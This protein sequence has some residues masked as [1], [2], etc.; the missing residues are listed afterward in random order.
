[1]KGGVWVEAPA[2]PGGRRL[3]RPPGGPWDPSILDR[4]PQGAW[5][6][7]TTRFGGD[8]LPLDVPEEPCSL[9][10]LGMPGVVKVGSRER[11]AP[12]VVEK[13]RGEAVAFF[14]GEWGLRFWVGI[15][16]LGSAPGQFLP[17]AS[18]AELRYIPLEEP[19]EGELIAGLDSSRVGMRLQGFDGRLH[20]QARS[21]PSVFGAIQ[22]APGGELLVHGP[23]GP[24][25]GGYPKLGGL[26]RADLGRAAQIRPGQSIRLVP[27]TREE[28]RAAGA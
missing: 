6:F 23:E 7:A 9:V 15:E 12:G 11:P 17:A 1:M 25:T 24:V 14:A 26:I 20:A 18:P 28:A 3:G 4:L 5:E 27:V 10:F 2:A 8:P 22:A 21:E 16:P 13:G 19:W